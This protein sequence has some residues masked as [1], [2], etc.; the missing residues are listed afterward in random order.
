M[1]CNQTVIGGEIIE[2][3]V[4]R[5]TPAGVAVSE[6]RVRHASHQIEAGKPRR[7][8]CEI[9][10]VALAELAEQSAG[11]PPGAMV[12]LSGFLARKS[13]MSMQLALH[14]SRIDLI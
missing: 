8:E 9:A 4:L 10:A 2:K 3:A 12:R 14:V 6:F 5:Y 7:V 11:M 1:D 13:R